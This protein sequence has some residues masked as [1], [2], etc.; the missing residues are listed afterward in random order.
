MSMLK[1]PGIRMAC[2]MKG[3]T[4]RALATKAGVAEGRIVDHSHGRLSDLR[5][6]EKVAIQKELGLPAEFLF[7]RADQVEAVIRALPPPM[8]SEV[9]ARYAAATE[10]ERRAHKFG[11]DTPPAPVPRSPVK[12]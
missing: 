1:F 12:S 7:G 6:T 3:Y 11:D 8:A 2:A 5:P 9:A 10:P 4:V